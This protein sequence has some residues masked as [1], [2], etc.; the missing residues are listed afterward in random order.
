MLFCLLHSASDTVR[1]GL[2][3]RGPERSV[4]G[5]AAAAREGLPHT[6]EGD[7]PIDHLEP[8]RHSLED[9]PRTIRPHGYAARAQGNTPDDR[10]FS[11]CPSLIF[12]CR[13]FCDSGS[14]DPPR[15]RLYMLY[16]SASHA[17]RRGT[18]SSPSTS[19][20][21]SISI[22]ISVGIAFFSVATAF[23]SPKAVFSHRIPDDVDDLHVTYDAPKSPRY[24]PY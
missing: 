15:A 4:R 16:I 18:T 11:L 10:K 24:F 13:R 3:P 8:L 12:F 22:L 5:K 21:L 19:R 6:G 1:R 17:P 14:S 9:F 2:L 7:H 23:T 20:Y